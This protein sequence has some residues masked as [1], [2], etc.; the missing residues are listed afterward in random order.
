MLVGYSRPPHNPQLVHNLV[1]SLTGVVSAHNALLAQLRSSNTVTE[2]GN[3]PGSE[4][5][6]GRAFLTSAPALES[7]LT[8]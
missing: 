3:S 8:R 4:P 6:V 7:S 1:A 5:R 2:S